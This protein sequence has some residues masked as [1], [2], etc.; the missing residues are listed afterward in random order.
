MEQFSEMNWSRFVR[1]SIEQKTE[2]LSLRE[3]LLKKLGQDEEF[4]KWCVDMGERVNK[5]IAKRLKDEGL[6]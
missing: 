3:E 1:K 4:E 5:G 6:L 2:E